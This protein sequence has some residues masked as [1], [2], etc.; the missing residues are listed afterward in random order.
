MPDLTKSIQQWIACSNDIWRNWFSDRPDGQHEFSMLETVLL[1]V[2]VINQLGGNQSLTKDEFIAKLN[3]SYALPINEVRQLCNKQKAGNIFC[4]PQLVSIP[5]GSVYAVKS[6]DT[7][8]QM[9]D[10]R[11]YI[12]LAY[13]SGFILEFVDALEF[14]FKP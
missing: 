14:R 13:E 4:R 1:D 8:G 10:G 7:T 9:M 6:I 12:E 11:P 2:L 5:Q 3:V